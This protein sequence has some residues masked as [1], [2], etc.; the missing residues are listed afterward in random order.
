MHFK[1]RIIIFF[2]L[3]ICIDVNS[4]DE[5]YSLNENTKIAYRD[6]GPPSG[7]PILL[8]TGLGAQLTLWPDFI[9]EL[10]ANNFRPMFMT[11]EML[12]F[13]QDFLRS[14]TISKLFK[15]FFIYSN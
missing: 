10:Q 3:I 7:I 9:D 12:D 15:I 1:H 6:Y 4:Y 8:V 2:F 5:G 11:I 14:L 13:Q